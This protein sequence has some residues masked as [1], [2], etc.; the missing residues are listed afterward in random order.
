[1]HDLGRALVV[2]G[3]LLLAAGVIVL[4]LIGCI[5]P[6]AGFPETSTGA[7]GDGQPRFPLRPQ[8]SSVS[9]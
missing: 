5:S 1:M 9:C 6:S 2:L 7:A 3:L 4:G 8:S